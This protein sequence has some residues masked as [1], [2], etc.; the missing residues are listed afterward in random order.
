MLLSKNDTLMSAGILVRKQQRIGLTGAIPCW[1]KQLE[2][3]VKLGHEDCTVKQGH[4]VEGTVV[5]TVMERIGTS[6]IGV[7]KVDKQFSN[8]FLDL[9][10]SASSLLHSDELRPL[11]ESFW[12]DS[13]VTG[14]QQ[15]ASNGKRVYRANRRGKD[16]FGDTSSLP[17]AGRY[18]ELVQGIYA[19]SSPEMNRQPEIR[20]GVCGAAIIRARGR[21]NGARKKTPTPGRETPAGQGPS[22]QVSTP[23]KKTPSGKSPGTPSLAGFAT[24]LDKLIPHEETTGEIAGFM[25]WSDIQS[26]YNGDRLLCFA[27]VADG[28]IEDGWKVV[29][30]SEK[31][32]ASAAGF[33][34]DSD[35]FITENSPKH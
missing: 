18:V 16:L 26:V 7:A 35:P 32:K 1:D 17:S 13:F 20:E 15:L 4:W 27:D 3:D 34:D 29:L 22:P 33:Q 5:G 24:P 6:D 28:L 10:G 19:T 14:P 9:N 2:S 8:R 11:N 31:R 12:I 25:H 30:A 21:K 23:D